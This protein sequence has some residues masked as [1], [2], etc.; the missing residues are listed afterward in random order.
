MHEK[1]NPYFFQ[2]GSE[3]SGIYYNLSIYLGVQVE[4]NYTK[5]KEIELSHL[6]FCPP[7][8]FW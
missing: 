8:Y 1:R 7:C 5:H 6:L 3:T 2:L 4:E